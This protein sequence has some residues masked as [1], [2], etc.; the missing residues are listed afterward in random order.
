[1]RLHGRALIQP[2]FGFGTLS[3]RRAHATRIISTHAALLGTMQVVLNAESIIDQGSR[4][5]SIAKSILN[6]C[7]STAICSAAAP[8]QSGAAPH[9]V[10]AG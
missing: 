5:E 8:D 9:L 10:H 6:I 4:Q 2:C 1:M 7:P 3:A